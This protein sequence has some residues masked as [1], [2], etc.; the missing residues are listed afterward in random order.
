VSPRDIAQLVSI[1][2]DHPD[3]K[4]EIV[5]GVSENQRAW[6]DNSNAIRL[7]YRPLDRS[8]AYAAG[9]LAKHVDNPN[10]LVEQYQGGTF[11][12]AEDG[13]D[14]SRAHL[15]SGRARRAAKKRA[16][17]KSKGARKKK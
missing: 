17:P 9:I 10:P 12:A 8:E 7:G 2:I 14:P 13:G 5:Y 1:G 11:V 6:Y 15:V 16:A 3:I 4:F